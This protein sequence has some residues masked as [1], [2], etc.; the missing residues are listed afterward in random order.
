MGS[1]GI[2]PLTIVAPLP[3]LCRHMANCIVRAE[4]EVFLGTNFW[5]HSDAS[6]LV[7]NSLR[8]LSKRAGERGT[9]VIVKVIYDRGDPRQVCENRLDVPE[10]KYTSSQVQFPPAAEIPNVDLQVIN[11]HR[12]TFG[13]FHAKFMVVDRRVALLQSSNVQDNDNLEMMIRMEGPIVDAIYDTALV[14]WGKSFDPPLPMLSS[15]AADA[16][17]P[18]L[19]AKFPEEQGETLPELTTDDQHYDSDIGQE[20][21]RVNGMVEPREGE[22]RTQAVTRHLSMLSYEQFSI[23]T[24]MTDTTTQ[25][26]TTGDASDADHEPPMRPYVAMPPHKPFPIAVVNRE[27]FGGKYTKLT[28]TQT[29]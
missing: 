18:S 4:K 28:P 11:Y 15:P 21:Q 1:H 19:D 22:S 13:T 8:E 26:N 17:I 29:I 5:I 10:K 16:P 7:T 9:K 24:D 23:Q 14:S 25:P 2:V 20:A 12:P 27:P 3:D 6:T